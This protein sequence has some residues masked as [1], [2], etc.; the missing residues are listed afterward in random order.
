MRSSQY[1]YEQYEEV[2]RLVA[3]KYI[4][5]G[6]CYQRFLNSIEKLPHLP[7]PKLSIYHSMVGS[8]A[9]KVFRAL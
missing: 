9:L 7:P 2:I 1:S 4:A 6:Y 3:R 8:I 5:Y